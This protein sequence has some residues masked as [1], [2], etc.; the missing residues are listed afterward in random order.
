[1]LTKNIKKVKSGVKIDKKKL[2]F[3]FWSII[4]LI[5]VIYLFY[6]N[7][8]MWQKRSDLSKDLNNLD[9]NI[10]SLKKEQE[11][12]SFRL[13]ETYSEEYLEKVARE[14]L[15]MQKAGEKVVVIK[16]SN[17]EEGNNN[18]EN[19]NILNSVLDWFNSLFK[20]E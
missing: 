6:C 20:P 1:M 15:G 16:K 11:I 2:S 12:L 10:E 19:K 7:I 4:C 14:D 18:S 9:F 13:D 5:F 8:K 3:L 17:S